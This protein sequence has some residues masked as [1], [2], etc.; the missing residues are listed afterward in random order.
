MSEAAFFAWR[1]SDPQVEADDEWW[2]IMLTQVL[3]SSSVHVRN[4]RQSIVRETAE[5]H[6]PGDTRPPIMRSGYRMWRSMQ[7]SELTKDGGLIEMRKEDFDTK[8]FFTMG[9]GHAEYHEAITTCKSAWMLLDETE[10]SGRDAEIHMMLSKMP[11]GVDEHVQKLKTKI[12]ERRACGQ[13]LKRTLAEEL[14]RLSVHVCGAGVGASV[15]KFG[16]KTDEEKPGGKKGG[17]PKKG[18][19]CIVCGEGGI[20]TCRRR[21]SRRRRRGNTSAS[22]S[23]QTASSGAA[24]APWRGSRALLSP[25]RCGR[26][27]SASM[28]KRRRTTTRRTSA[29][30][31]CTPRC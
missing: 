12:K 8:S 17:R 11:A 22:A 14:V 16:T 23:A 24:R 5:E 26:R 21:A 6:E 30:S 10:R 27:A 25:R 20:T 7:A 4:L 31:S 28:A 3:L 19:P 29:R 13:P 18:P 15:R 2:Q 9:M 1:A